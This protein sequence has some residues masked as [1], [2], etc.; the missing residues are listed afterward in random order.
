MPIL[1][2]VVAC[3]KG[4]RQDSGWLKKFLTAA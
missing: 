2:E 1:L 3:A 4:T